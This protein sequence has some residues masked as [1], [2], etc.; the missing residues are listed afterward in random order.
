MDLS[1]IPLYDHHAHA[2]LPEA[3]WRTEPL[4]ALFT[5]ATDP[6]MWPHVR[7]NVFFL[8]SLPELASFYQ[9]D[10]RLEVVLQARQQA[11][12]EATTRT[13]MA[14][15]NIQRWLIDDGYGAGRLLSLAECQAL[16]PPVGRLLRLET[17][18]AFFVQSHDSAQKALAAFAD[19]LQRIAPTL[20]GFKSI[21]AYRSGL[22]LERHPQ[23]VLEQ[24]FAALKR[25]LPHSQVPRLVQKPILDSLLWLALELAT[26]LGKP[27]QFHTGY[28]DPDL[29]LRLANPLHLRPIFEDSTYKGLKVVL[30][31]GYPYIQ[32]A[33]YLASVYPG[34]Y[35][36]LGLSFPHLSRAGM[37][38]AL[39]QALHLTPVSKV[40]FSTDATRSA[41]MFWLAARQIRGVLAQV[42]QSM[43]SDSEITKAQA[44][45]MAQR[46]LQQNAQALYS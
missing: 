22:N 14:E 16:G 41:E 2:L 12:F 44:D 31:H 18:F 42:L 26:Q 37:R 35:L 29:D 7:N 32:E 23:T 13:L 5:E 19:H 34:A 24:Q 11:P 30:L 20:A 8:R 6:A 45:W 17:E 4:E 21:V 10:S 1:H 43:V 27:V 3:A 33:G 25:T 15:A 9:C 46:M 28:G 39:Q 38:L 40:L 36:D